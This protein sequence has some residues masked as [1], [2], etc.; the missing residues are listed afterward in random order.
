MF[1]WQC[2]LGNVGLAILVWMFALQ[3][4]GHLVLCTDSVNVGFSF[5]KCKFLFFS[6]SVKILVFHTNSVNICLQIFVFH[7]NRVNIGFFAN[8][9]NIGFVNL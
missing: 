7:T 2:W 1:V 9:V 6:P 5:Q 4:K 3:P 8:S